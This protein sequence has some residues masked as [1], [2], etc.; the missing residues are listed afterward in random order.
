[1]PRDREGGNEVKL[2]ITNRWAAFRAGPGTTHRRPIVVVAAGLVALAVVLPA[3][4]A[5]TSAQDAALQTAMVTNIV[6]GL[7]AASWRA[8]LSD[9]IVKDGTLSVNVAA[10]DEPLASRIC[11]N[12]AAVTY[13]PDTA[14][15]LGLTMVEIGGGGHV[16]TACLPAALR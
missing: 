5:T 8:D 10:R 1:M 3:K 16:W 12:I 2:Q 7:S 6:E 9:L 14:K 11:D 4:P 15:P 13:D